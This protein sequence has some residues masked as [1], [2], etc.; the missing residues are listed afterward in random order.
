MRFSDI[1]MTAATAPIARRE[2]DADLL[3]WIAAV[4]TNGGTVSAGRAAII[5]AFIFAEKAS[6]AWALT[7]DYWG[8][9]AENAIQ[10]L[11]S[12]K[13]RRLATAVNAPVFAANLQYTFDGATNYI[14]TGFIPS[15]HS[16]LLTNTSGRISVYERVNFSSNAATMGVGSSTARL[17]SIRPKNITNLV[18][19]IMHNTTN[20][21]LVVP[22]L[23]STATTSYSRTSGGVF[24]YFR[25]GVSVG[26]VT[27]TAPGIGLPTVSAYIGGSNISG[28][29]SSPRAAAVGFTTIG[30]PLSAAQE[31]AQYN[32]VQAWAASVGAAV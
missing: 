32:A 27:P 13:Q 5:D 6:G 17:I 21:V 1:L 25:R 24:E 12:L 23:E 30:A 7:D 16:T 2:A 20:A 19:T 8:L 15:T 9:W 11:T 22:G 14:N 18:G 26:T 3:A 29:L 10:A 31:L 28:V 4:E